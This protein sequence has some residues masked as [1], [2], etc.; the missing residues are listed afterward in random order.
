M[1]IDKVRKELYKKARKEGKSKAQAMREA[2]YKETTA[3]H[4]Q[5]E[6]PLVLLGDKELLAERCKHI[7]KDFVLSGLLEEAVDL[8]NKASDRIRAKELLGKYLDLFK[9]DVKQGISIF[10]NMNDLHK[11]LDRI[12]VNRV[13]DTQITEQGKEP[14][15][16]GEVGK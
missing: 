3:T 8:T 11:D 14:A 1:S 13:P 10:N 5:G 4:C 12:I 9:E 16:G 7:T 15:Q 6:T 2:G